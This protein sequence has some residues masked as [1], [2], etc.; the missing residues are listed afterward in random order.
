MKLA[1]WVGMVLGL[2]LICLSV[3][4]AAAGWPAPVSEGGSETVKSLLSADNVRSLLTQAPTIATGFPPFGTI[5]LVSIGASIAVLSGLIEDFARLVSRI[6]SRALA[7]PLVFSLGLLAHQLSD[8]LILVYLPACAMIFS[9][10]GRHPALGVLAGFAAFSGAL[11]A[12]FGPGLQDLVLLGIT[13]Q[14]AQA[15]GLEWA[16][17]PLANWW[18]SAASA[19]ALLFAGWVVTDRVLER[20]PRFRPAP[21]QTDEMNPNGLGLV[22]AAAA[23]AV[24]LALY[25]G[26]SL[27]QAAPLADYRAHSLAR[28]TPAFE[29]GAAF[30][31]LLLMSMGLAYAVGARRWRSA[32]DVYQALTYGM[33]RLAPFFLMAVFIGFL[34]AMI[35]LSRLG[36]AAVTALTLGL[37]ESR[38]DQVVLIAALT[39]TTAI[40]DFIVFSASAKWALMAPTLI[41]AFAQAGLSPELVTASFRLGDSVANILNPLQPAAALAI[42]NVRRWAPE[43]SLGR[44]LACMALYAI[45]F[46]LVGGGLLAL[47]IARGWAFGPFT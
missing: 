38:A 47:W 35:D 27:G 7:T 31:T 46:S 37:R 1:I 26:L 30:L 40:L 15:A 2:T 34:L 42:L 39:G 20:T 41:P 29:A 33:E 8:A 36:D 10:H 21:P 18:F 32:E 11:Y 3:V 6:S 9:H 44:F 25:A 22:A 23:G 5:M 17:N 16:F 45:A 28:H 24:V 14:A 13:H 4:G 19:V 43:I 12:S